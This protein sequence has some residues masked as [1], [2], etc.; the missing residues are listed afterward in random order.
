MDVAAKV[1]PR[2]NAR[3]GEVQPMEILGNADAVISEMM[4]ANDEEL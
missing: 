1:I 4:K 3:T 2:K